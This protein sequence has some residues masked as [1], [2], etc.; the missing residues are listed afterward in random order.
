[1]M[2]VSIMGIKEIISKIPSAIHKIQPSLLV[3][4]DPSGET[5][6]VKA[7]VDGNLSSTAT[8]TSSGAGWSLAGDSTTI[9]TSGSNVDVYSLRSGGAS[10]T[11]LQT[12]TVT[13]SDSN[14]TQIVS[15]VRATP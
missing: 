7:D 9:D 5:V 4:V 14:K 13:Y 12:I 1:M 8:I 15:T 11:V 10:G 6:A 3:A 2:E